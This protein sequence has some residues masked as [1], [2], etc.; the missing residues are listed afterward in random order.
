MNPLEGFGH[1]SRGV[2]GGWMWG[3]LGWDFR[4]LIP[5]FPPS[6][7][8]C[9][10]RRGTAWPPWCRRCSAEGPP[11]WLWMKKVGV[12]GGVSLGFQHSQEVPGAWEMLSQEQDSPSSWEHSLGKAFPGLRGVGNVRRKGEHSQVSGVL[13][14][15]GM[16]GMWLF[17]LPCALSGA[18]SPAG[19]PFQLGKCCWWWPCSWQ[20]WNPSELE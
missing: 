3:F 2:P 15:L 10:S 8:R 14:M 7:G 18:P 16:L 13:G 1:C 12:P 4:G 6:A 19:A 20:S 17:P 5:L 9:T 11:C